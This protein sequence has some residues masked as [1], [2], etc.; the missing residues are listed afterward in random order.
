M[1]PRKNVPALKGSKKTV[2]KAPRPV[3]RLKKPP[4][5]GGVRT[6]SAAWERPPGPP[7]DE[8]W[9]RAVRDVAGCMILNMTR[10]A[11]MRGCAGPRVSITRFERQLRVRAYALQAHFRR[12]YPGPHHDGCR[13]REEMLLA[14]MAARTAE[15]TG[16]W[17]KEDLFD[18]LTRQFGRY[19]QQ[20]ASAVN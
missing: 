14:S 5:R 13:C 17:T 20:L 10:G 3:P 18:E 19:T 8:A 12:A 9:E 4:P 2:K 11:I 1:A 7:L 6:A 15:K 16:R